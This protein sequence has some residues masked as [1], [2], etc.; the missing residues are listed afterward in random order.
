MEMRRWGTMTK[1]FGRK[2]WGG[3]GGGVS[4]QDQIKEMSANKRESNQTNRRW[5]GG[6][7]IWNIR[8]KRNR[9]KNVGERAVQGYGGTGAYQC[10]WMF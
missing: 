8:E 9:N 4:R 2:G 7:R 6:V 1:S 5:R 3:G 10:G